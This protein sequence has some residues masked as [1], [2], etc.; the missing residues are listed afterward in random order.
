MMGT[1]QPSGTRTQ[2]P[3]ALFV[4][5]SHSC[6]PKL[7]RRHRAFDA[8]LNASFFPI[9]I[10]DKEVKYDNDGFVV[11]INSVLMT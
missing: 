4:V 11:K 3:I 10:R 5:L 6:V 8:N 2:S 1:T 7:A 9:V